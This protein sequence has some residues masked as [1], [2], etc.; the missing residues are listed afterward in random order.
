MNLLATY[1]VYD[2]YIALCAAMKTPPS[3]IGWCL[4]LGA[5]MGQ[6]K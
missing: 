3:I 5:K 6:R 4:Y 2:E 1:G